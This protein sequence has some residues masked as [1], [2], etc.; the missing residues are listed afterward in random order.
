MS[1]SM[2]A[3]WSHLNES[4][5]S[6]NCLPFQ[7]L[8]IPLRK[9]GLRFIGILKK[10]QPCLLRRGSAPQILLQPGW[11]WADEKAAWTN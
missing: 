6:S 4:W 7:C 1:D 3:P 9:P 11:A 8:A 5:W 2:C 10:L